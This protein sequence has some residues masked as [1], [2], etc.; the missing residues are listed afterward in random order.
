MNFYKVFLLMLRHWVR[1]VLEHIEKKKVVEVTNIIFKLTGR[2]L[3]CL[4]WKI[5]AGTR[6]W[7]PMAHRPK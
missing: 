5:F 2:G 6:Q 3:A 1:F 7:V 4:P